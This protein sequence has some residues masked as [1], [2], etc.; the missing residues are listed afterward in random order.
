[1]RQYAIIGLGSFGMRMLEKLSDVNAELIIADRDPDLI[2]R[3]KD[4][5]GSAYVFDAVNDEALRRIIPEG[6][7]ACV[8]DLGSN[9]EST[10]LVTNGLKK[11]GVKEIIVRADSDERGEILT[12]VGAT[13]V[14]YPER[15]AAARIVPLLVS[16][17]L[18]SF[19]PIGSNLVLAE[20]GTPER[21]IGMTLIETKLRQSHGINVVALRPE[22]GLE[23]RYFD[24]AYRLGKGD[25]LL[26]AGTEPDVLAFSGL[27]SHASVHGSRDIFKGLLKGRNGWGK[28][29][30]GG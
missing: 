17:T 27:E 20:V 10:I 14:V 19:M 21:L 23:Y 25:I 28:K 9:I 30:A 1:M 18:F 26:V 13:K 11:I 3:C 15:E 22:A 12:L 24:A 5:A 16:P 2:Q 7:D 6:L 8:V 29:K 4:L